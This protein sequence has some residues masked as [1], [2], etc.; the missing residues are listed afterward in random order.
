SLF[1]NQLIWLNDDLVSAT[2]RAFVYPL[3]AA[4]LYYLAKNRLI[5]CLTTMLLQGLFYPQLLLIEMAI[6]SLKLLVKNSKSSVKSTLNK[7]PYI[8]WILGLIVTAIALY[9]VTQKPPELATVVTAQ[10]MKQM[11]EFNPGGRSPFFSDGWFNYWFAGSSGLDLP[12]F[13]PIVWTSIALPWLW[14]TK[15]PVIKLITKKIDILKQIVIASLSMF[16]MAHILLPRLHLPSRYTYH[17]LRFAM[18]IATGIVITILFD[19][20][21]N[22]FRTKIKANKSFKLSDKIKITLITLFSLTVI[23]FPALPHVFIDWF[24]N[25]RIGT[26]TEIYEYLAQQPKDIMVASLSKEINIIPAFT[27]RSIFLGEEFA[28]A[29][30]PSYYNQVQ[31]RAIA[32]IQAQYTSDISVLKSFIQRYNIDY[33]LLNKVAFTS[34]YSLDQD[35]LIHSSWSDVTKNAIA[36]LE[37]GVS[38][39]LVEFMPSCS[40]VSTKDLNLLDTA[41]ILNKQLSIAERR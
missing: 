39:I 38:P 31:E 26:E 17:S 24:Q 25:W 37:S 18:A 28:L 7:Q 12:L 36:N 29:Y 11:P 32:L 4:F 2:P 40:V 15:L 9:P 14:K 19:L 10:Q 30:H 23:I 22:W 5:P 35:W 3:F 41:C 13:P 21:K 33:L 20:G 16:V 34:D 27:Q 8:W 6:L 1:I